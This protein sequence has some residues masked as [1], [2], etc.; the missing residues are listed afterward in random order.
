VLEQHQASM[1][2]FF[3]CHPAYGW[4]IHVTCGAN[5]AHFKH[6]QFYNTIPCKVWSA[7]CNL[8]D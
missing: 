3:I 4:D 8:T 6:L 1:F 2:H 7:L 5:Y